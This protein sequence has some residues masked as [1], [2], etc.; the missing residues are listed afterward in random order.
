M[1][2]TVSFAGLRRARKRPNPATS[3]LVLTSTK[4][5]PPTSKEQISIDEDFALQLL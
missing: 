3:N 4:P 5:E 1:I 2:K